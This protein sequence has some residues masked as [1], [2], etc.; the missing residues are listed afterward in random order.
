[1]G[2]VF[3]IN[4]FD[5]IRFTEPS[6]IPE[7]QQIYVTGFFKDADSNI[8]VL[9]FYNGLYKI[10]DD[11][12][13]NYLPDSLHPEA[14]SN[15]IF[16]MI[17]YD[18]KK[19]IIATDNNIYWF[20]G[21]KFSQFDPDNSVIRKQFTS[22]AYYKKNWLFF[23]CSS[24]IVAYSKKDGNWEYAGKM[25]TDRE[26]NSINSDDDKILVSTDRGLLIF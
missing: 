13:I 20:D 21:Q 24:G 8:W 3:G 4:L 16:G 18:D 5:G 7:K 19:F 9:S 22:L 2:T 23:G 1:M 15:S 6:A 17:Q 14:N 12:F 10:A 26:V 25:F 11:R